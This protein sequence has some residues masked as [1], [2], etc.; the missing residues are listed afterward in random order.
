MNT[1]Q[2][3]ISKSDQYGNVF[4]AYMN[5]GGTYRPYN[6]SAHGPDISKCDQMHLKHCVDWNPMNACDCLNS[7]YT[8]IQRRHMR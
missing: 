2:P 1:P 7:L 3:I 6:I 4:A 8:T 5:R